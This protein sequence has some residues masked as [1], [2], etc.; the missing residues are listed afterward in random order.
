M[1]PLES[2]LVTW[3]NARLFHDCINNGG[4]ISTGKF[5]MKFSK[6]NKGIFVQVVALE[7][8]SPINEGVYYQTL[9]SLKAPK[10]PQ[11]TEEIKMFKKEEETKTNEATDLFNI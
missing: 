9:T 2:T 8:G 10:L 4:I 5:G 11:Q 6:T 3:D 1:I 7:T